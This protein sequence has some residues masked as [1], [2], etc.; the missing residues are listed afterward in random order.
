MYSPTADDAVELRDA[1]SSI[2]ANKNDPAGRNLLSI[3]E[4]CQTL[5][6]VKKLVDDFVKAHKNTKLRRPSRLHMLRWC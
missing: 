1:I 6:N 2:K 3:A 5:L 4:Q